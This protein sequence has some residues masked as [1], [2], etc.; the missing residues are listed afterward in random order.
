MKYAIIIL[1]VIFSLGCSAKAQTRQDLTE[2]ERYKLAADYSK[3]KRGLS[4]LV[5]KGGK[6]IFEDYENGYTAEDS[7]QLA[8]GTKS[9]SGVM[10]AAAIEDKLI[11]N[12]D[13]KVSDTIIE[14]QT[15]KQKS[16]IT[17]RQLLSLT[18]GIDTGNNGRPPSYTEAI[19]FPVKYDAGE[20]F[21]Y[22]PVPFQVFGE[23]MR[24][25]LLPKKETVLDYLKR[26]VLNPIGLNVT[27]WTTQDGQIN[28]PS[29]AFLTAKEWAKFGQFLLDSG[30]WN[31]KQIVAKKLLDELVIG[32]KA[33]PNYGLSFWLNRSSDGKATLAEKPKTRLQELLNIEAETDQ[34]SQ[35]GFGKDI[36]KDSF[37]A[38]G[39]GKQRLY[40][41]PSMNLV[42]VR[43]GQ[44]AKFDDNEFLQRLI[45]GQ[46]SA[47][48]KNAVRQL[49]ALLLNL[50]LD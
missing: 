23:V 17:L 39:A 42:V 9:F 38:A 37:V 18:S 46:K 25:K 2:N 8:S 27:S 29:G 30:K 20:K 33:N 5:M 45:F 49:S 47:R 16:R 31:G 35:Q 10:L 24:R 48:S 26:R 40:V 14:W 36:P 3:D 13:E 41:I 28:I 7:H 4:V 19:K 15:D 1:A 44:Q 32:S 6:T 22:G 34:I 12:F 50:S 21:E 11:K 43:Q